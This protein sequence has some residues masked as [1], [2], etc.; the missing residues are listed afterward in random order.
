MLSREFDG[1]NKRLLWNDQKTA[2]WNVPLVNGT[3]RGSPLCQ[4]HDW[5]KDITT[6]AQ[7]HFTKLLSVKQL[8][9]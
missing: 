3:V 9:K 2:D 7:E 6:W 5:V 4:T 1:S 8:R